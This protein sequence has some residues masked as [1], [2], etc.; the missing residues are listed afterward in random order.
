[1]ISHS[2]FEMS[3]VKI[4]HRLVFLL[5]FNITIH[6]YCTYIYAFT[7]VHLSV[8]ELAS[9]GLALARFTPKMCAGVPDNCVFSLALIK[10]IKK[11]SPYHDSVIIHQSQ[12]V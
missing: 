9:V 8:F 11:T 7:L 4:I 2:R 5:E 10:L 3:L 12:H 6:H 1:M